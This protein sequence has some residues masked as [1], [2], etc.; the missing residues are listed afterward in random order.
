MGFTEKG[1]VEDFI[2]Q[3]L[4]SLGWSYVDPGEMAERRKEGFEEVLVTEDLRSAVRRINEGVEFADADLDF[5]LVSLRTIPSTVDGVR[6]FLD[7]LRNGLV[8]PLQREHEERVVSL[9]DFEN[10]GN[11]E[12][13]VTRQF[14]V[15]GLRGRIRADVVLFVNGI[16]LVLVECKN[17]TRE[18]VDWTDAYSDIKVY[19]EKAPELFKYVQFSIATDGV[20]SQ[21]FPNAFNEEGEDLLSEWKDP[22][23]YQKEGFREDLLKIA[24][25]GL[26]SKKNLLDLVEN[27]TFIRKEKG[28]DT[29][30]TARYMQYRATNRIFHRVT[31]TLKGK[32]QKKFGLIWHWL[33]AGK[34]Y[35]MAFSAWKLL[36]CPEAENPSIFVMVDRVKLEEQIEDDFSFLEIPIERIGSIKELIEILQWGK[37]GKR[38]IFLVTIEKFSPTEFEQLEEEVEKIEI[39]RENVIVLADEVHRT[40]YGKFATMMRS[41]LRNAFVF[42]FTGTPLSKKERNTFQEF[43]PEKELYLDRYSMLDALNDG[44]TVPL[45]Y[46]PRLPRYHMNK[47]QR[48][49]LVSFEEEELK[50]LSKEEQREL[51][52]KVRVGKAFLKKTERIKTVAQDIAEH[53]KETVDPTELKALVVAIDRQACVR[54]KKALDQ[55]LPP[56]YS[57]IVMTFGSKE[58]AKSIREYYQ[59][60]E[61]KYETRNLK[62]I[63]QKVI[64][65]FKTK[66][67]PRIL[68]V[69]GMLIT[70]FDAPNLWTMYMDKPLKEHSILQAI[71]RTNRPFPNK[72]YGLIADYIGVL[73]D[74]KE[75]FQQYEAR[76]AQGLKVVIRGLEK[77]KQEF[78]ELLQKGLEFFED[79][80]IEDTR[81]S[82]QKALDILID[83][84]KAKEFQTTVKDLM[85][86]YEMLSGEPF[87]REYLPQYTLLVKI[88]AAYHKK[89]KKT[90]VDE[91]KIDRL[92]KKTAK[93]IQ[94]TIDVDEIEK[95]Y[96][97]VSVDQDYIKFL[98]RAA[99]KTRGGAIDVAADI[100]H[101]ARE[102]PHSPFFIN[103]GRDV[104]RT[105]EDLRNRRV[106]TEKA[107]QKL[108]EMAQQVTE[109]K[110]EEKEIGTDKYPLYEAIKNV[111]P[112]L[113][114]EAAIDFIKNLLSH[115]ENRKLLFKGWQQQRD[116]RRK[117]RAEIRLLL[118]SEFKA[119]RAKIDELL[120]NTYQA[121][122]VM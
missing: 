61:D 66:R 83:P 94:Q 89:F 4:Q 65:A 5:V 112:D 53:F 113:K 55:F 40:H 95:D 60:L 8:V 71:A 102:H 1:T 6:K 58:K 12:F 110:K 116:I 82:L 20:E 106:E 23:P 11:N 10:I 63:H 73:T 98:K 47:K 97:T 77:E 118:L 105:Y 101:E 9:I 7:V 36:H 111:L 19:E 78:K 35:S 84:E 91:L 107:V 31:S 52:R 68:I 15:E 49:E 87:L 88:Y 121:L 74:L 114:K 48:R 117:V 86:S 18:E 43:C 17:P 54:Y 100:Q 13:V 28:E 44:F 33:G 80:K 34:T 2:V 99:P 72:K 76:D 108:L 56:T 119:K 41:I 32:E 120:E 67:D 30:I 59:K 22:Y 37:G 109:W 104:E 42:G 25:Y 62:E 39:E 27:F 90:K 92:S 64:E 29:K 26:L 93:L 96:P 51:R 24:V 103:L 50:T 45:R 70:G 81:E 79:I 14:T 75:A 115:L 21:Y 69:T 57:E 46:Q 3:E 122:Q 85:K 16:P 38:G